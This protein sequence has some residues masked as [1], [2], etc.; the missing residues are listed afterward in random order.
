MAYNPKDYYFRKAKKEN[1]VARSIYKLEEINDRF[2]LIRSGHHI[3]DLGAAPGSWAQYCSQKIG[4]KGS[5]LG[6]DLQPIRLSLP[7]AKFVVGD[8]LKI[9]ESPEILAMIPESLNGVISDMAPKT[10]GIRITDQSRSVELCRM[11]LQVAHQFLSPG[12]Y[13]ICKLLEG[14]EARDLTQEMKTEFSR[15]ELL[16]PKSTRKQSTEI[17]IVGIGKRPVKH[18]QPGLQTQHPVC[19]P[20][21]QP[22]PRMSS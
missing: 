4:A 21:T 12:G 15:V 7:N 2:H 22:I 16:R 19:T 14:N 8:I 20:D 6:I 3:L 13:F 18:S 5:V 11:A 9:N 1:F 17:F 10:C